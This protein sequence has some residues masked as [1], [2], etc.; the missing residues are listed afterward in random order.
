MEFEF[1]EEK[2]I[3]MLTACAIQTS[4]LF[5]LFSSSFM[6]CFTSLQRYLQCIDVYKVINYVRMAARIT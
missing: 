2:Y 6:K 4:R 3:S 5:P 1:F